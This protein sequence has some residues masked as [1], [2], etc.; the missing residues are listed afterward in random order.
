MA[1][2]EKT[3]LQTLK[4]Y[5]RAEIGL[6]VGKYL[7][8]LVPAVSIT[9]V[10]WNE[11]FAKCDG[12]SLPFGF[13]TLLIAIIGAMFGILKKDEILSKKLSGLVYLGL[14]FCIFGLAFMFLANVMA[15]MGKIFLFT[16]LSIFASMGVDQVDKS[17]VS[18]QVAFY[19]N[20]VDENGLDPKVEAKRQKAAAEKAKAE[21]EAQE[22]V[23]TE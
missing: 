8:P 1:K 20:L 12:I 15:E 21:K 5:K 17:Y 9:A 11:W 16:G 22:K 14:T 4:T 6:N 18:K 2:K 19:Q 3:T 13:T 10:N 7:M 23:P